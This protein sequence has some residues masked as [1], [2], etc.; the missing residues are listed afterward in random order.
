MK[1][2]VAKLI[3][4]AILLSALSLAVLP[5]AT[6]RSQEAGNVAFASVNV[7]VREGPGMDYAQIGLITANTQ[8]PV[9][10]RDET[11]SWLYVEYDP[12]Q[13]GWSA[14]WLL[15]FEGDLAALPVI[16]GEATEQVPPSAGTQIYA[17][18]RAALNLRPEPNTSEP[19]IAVIPTGTV[20]LAHARD[21]SAMWVAVTY[22]SQ[23]GWVAAQYVTLSA[24]IESLPL[25]EETTPPVPPDQGAVVVNLSGVGPNTRAIFELGQT[26]GNDPQRFTK[27]GDSELALPYTFQGFDQGTYNLGP[28]SSLEETIAFFEGSFQHE[29]E[30]ANYGVTVPVLVDPFWADPEVCLPGENMLECEYRSYKPSVAII[31]LRMHGGTEDWKQ[32][33]QAGMERV[34]QTSLDHGVIPVLTLQIR[35]RDNPGLADEMNFIL[36]EM[37]AQYDIPVWDLWASTY[38]LPDHGV[39]PTNHLT[40]SPQNNFDFADAENLQY[41]KVVH[42]LELLQMLDILRQQVIPSE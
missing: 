4:A 10:A 14:A 1:R 26:L 29:S 42:N 6:V 31:L 23:R 34:I 36:R 7:R 16:A 15:T 41:G 30:A 20:L 21:A 25:D 37:G 38:N 19:R 12:G 22:K 40:L 39:D 13:Q 3:P 35:F 9:K 33:Y 28:W 5:S 18:T 2:L 27:V 32:Q 8:V 11:F 17:T 24:P